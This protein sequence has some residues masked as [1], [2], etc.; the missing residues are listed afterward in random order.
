MYQT[1]RG[2]AVVYCHATAWDSIAGGN[3]VKTEL[4]VLRKGQ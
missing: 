4:D 3:G 1:T 2:A